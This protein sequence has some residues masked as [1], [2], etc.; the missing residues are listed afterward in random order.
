ME[1]IPK[2]TPNMTKEEL[3]EYLWKLANVL[4]FNIN[5]IDRKISEV[6]KNGNKT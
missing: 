3:F 5:D 2:P 4:E 1:M 6:Q